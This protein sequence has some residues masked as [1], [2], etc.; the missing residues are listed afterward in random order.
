MQ[1]DA[2][3]LAGAECY[4]EA[5]KA[6]LVRLLPIGTRVRLEFDAKLDRI[7]RFGRRLAYVFAGTTNVNLAMVRRGAAGPYFFGGDRGRYAERLL[8][9]ARQ[10]R[11]ARRG[12]WSVCPRT[13]LD[14]ARAIQT[15]G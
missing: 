8:R 5:S 11:A 7:D 6:E 1:I 14:P 15:V 4:G 12:L 9:T 3:E 13:K 2:P 10:A